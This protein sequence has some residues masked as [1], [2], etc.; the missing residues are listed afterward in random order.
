MK[1]HQIMDQIEI[2]HNNDEGV[3]KE[4]V[5]CIIC[6]ITEGTSGTRVKRRYPPHHRFWQDGDILRQA[7]A[8]SV[9]LITDSSQY[10]EEE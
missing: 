7:R 4:V 5:K 2:P 1:K 10:D 3:N 6:G 8:T 9:E